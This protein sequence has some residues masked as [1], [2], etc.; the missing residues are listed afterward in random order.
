MIYNKKAHNR[1]DLLTEMAIHQGRNRSSMRAWLSLRGHY[2]KTKR[3][4]PDVPNYG[5]LTKEQIVEEI[6]KVYR[7]QHLTY[8]SLNYAN[9]EVLWA[10]L[11]EKV[12]E[13]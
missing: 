5:G 7:I 11:Q 10:I 9:K 12:N 13:L 2:A 1:D 6:G 4:H 3:D 8:V